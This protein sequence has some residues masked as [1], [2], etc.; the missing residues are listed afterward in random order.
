MLF[1]GVIKCIE[2]VRFY[3][4]ILG[5]LFGLQ[6][7]TLLMNFLM[8][9]FIRLNRVIVLMLLLHMS[10][11]YWLGCGIFYTDDCDWFV[12][13]LFQLGL[14]FFFCLDIFCLFILVMRMLIFMILLLLQ[15]RL[16]FDGHY[17]LSAHCIFVTLVFHGTVLII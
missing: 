5:F 17:A 16:P 15:P 6:I 2:I 11:F 8:F 1:L 13:W 10:C 3:L 4:L 9:Y 14:S 12:F 7:A